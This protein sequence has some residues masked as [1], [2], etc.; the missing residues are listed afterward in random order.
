[1]AK[2]FT[3]NRTE[4]AEILCKFWS[5]NSKDENFSFDFNEKKNA[6]FSNRSQI[7]PSTEAKLI[8]RSISFLEFESSL[9]KLRGK[10]PGL[11]SIPYAM[12]KQ[13]P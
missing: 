1:M 12:I 13:L 10:S 3:D 8:E 11:D 5:Q 9:S 7:I 6:V 2:S 4:F